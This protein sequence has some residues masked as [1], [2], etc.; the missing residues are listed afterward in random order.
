MRLAQFFNVR[1]LHCIDREEQPNR[2]CKR[3][4]HQTT[5]SWGRRWLG[6]LL[7]EGAGMRIGKDLMLGKIEDRRRRGQ[8][9]IRW[10]DGIT[11]SMNMSLNKLWE[12]VMD[13]EDWRAAVHGVTKSQT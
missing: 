8:Q 5:P 6:P 13:R 3:T 12:L 2:N 10:F 1:T 11:N 4:V 7:P 9:R